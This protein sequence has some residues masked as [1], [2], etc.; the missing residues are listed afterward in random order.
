MHEALVLIARAFS[1]RFLVRA[2][3]HGASRVNPP[4]DCVQQHAWDLERS[5]ALQLADAGRTRDVDLRQEPANHVDARKE[6]PFLPKQGADG[7]TDAELLS[8]ERPAQRL[9]PDGDVAAVVVGGGD[10][11]QRGRNRLAVGQ[12]DACIAVLDDV[13]MYRCAIT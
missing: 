12:E 1:M 8:G 9:R 4:F 7:V 11:N 6:Q 2:P 5:R 10:A 3:H 13:G